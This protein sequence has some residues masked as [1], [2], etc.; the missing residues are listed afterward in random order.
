MLQVELLYF[1]GC[2][3]YQTA[4]RLLREALAEERLPADVALIEVADETDARRL[5]FVGS[6]TLRF[7][8][9]DPFLS[10]EAN[11]GMECRLFAT[12]E[13]LKGWPTKDMLRDAVREFTPV[14]DPINR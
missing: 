7:N 10:G 8:G 11:Y 2:P 4:D 6:P 13:G 5:R 9:I 14:S 3:S 12:P 1:E